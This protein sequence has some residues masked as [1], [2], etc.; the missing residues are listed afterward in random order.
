MVAIDHRFNYS[1]YSE[2]LTL[3][4]PD[5]VAPT[6]PVFQRSFSDKEGINLQWANSGSHDVKAN[7]L[8][9]RGVGEQNYIEIYRCNSRPSL[10]SFT[11]RKVNPG[12]EYEYTLYAIDDAGLK[13]PSISTL[14]LKAFEDKKLP[15]PQQLSYQIDTLKR[16]ITLQW[17]SSSSSAKTIVYRSLNG[18]PYVTHRVVDKATIFI[19]SPY[20][21]GDIIKYRIKGSDERGWQSDFS[22]EIEIRTQ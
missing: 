4:K 5:K 19:D 10:A 21:K 2:I 15:A 22:E 16:L 8:L 9:R 20:R 18:K 17:K 11:D 1:G 3:N 12:K 13:S 6:S 14:T 7:V